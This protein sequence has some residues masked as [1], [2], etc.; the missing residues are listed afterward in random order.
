MYT[1]DFNWV[2]RR[3]FVWVRKFPGLQRIVFGMDGWLIFPFRS[4]S[5]VCLVVMVMGMEWAGRP[6]E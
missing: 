1:V 6:R 2:V 4:T 3:V 5:E